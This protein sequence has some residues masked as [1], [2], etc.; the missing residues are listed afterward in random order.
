MCCLQN[1]SCGPVV[2]IPEKYLGS[3]DFMK[4]HTEDVQ[5]YLQW[6]PSQAFKST[7][8]NILTTSREAFT[9]NTSKMQLKRD[10]G[11]H[12]DSMALDLLRDK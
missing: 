6:T 3:V 2:K 12:R 1:S 8:D 11:P 10:I 7:V 4:F 9:L 5:L